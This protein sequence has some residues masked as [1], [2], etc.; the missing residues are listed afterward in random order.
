MIRQTA[1]IQLKGSES[2]L[3]TKSIAVKADNGGRAEAQICTDKYDALPVVFRKDKT[4]FPVQ[5]LS[6]KKV[7]GVIADRLFLSVQPDFFR[8]ERRPFRF[9]L[10]AACALFD[11]GAFRA[12]P[13]KR[14]RRASFLR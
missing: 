14:R 3:N 11:R 9:S 2:A 1:Q 4:D 8:P 5:P 13:G 12:L 10:C 6:P 7:N